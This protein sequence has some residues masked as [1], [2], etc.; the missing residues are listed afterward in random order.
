MKLWTIRARTL[1]KKVN[2]VNLVFMLF[3]LIC[4]KNILNA[5]S[6]S[7]FIDNDRV[8]TAL[9]C[10]AEPSRGWADT[11]VYLSENSPRAKDLLSYFTVQAL[12][13]TATEE[14]TSEKFL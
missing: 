6:R 10:N 7:Q 9:T 5:N 8:L 1:I 12:F 11:S 13:H 14:M 2:E 4:V 3:R